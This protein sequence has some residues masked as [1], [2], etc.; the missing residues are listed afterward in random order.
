MQTPASDSDYFIV[1]RTADVERLCRD[2][3]GDR[4]EPVVGLGPRANTA[5]PVLQPGD[6]RAVVGAG[7]GIYLLAD[8]HVLAALRKLLG[9]RLCLDAGSIRVW[10]PGAR[11]GCDPAWHPHVVGL[12]DEDH[13]DTLEH[14]AHEYHLSRPLVRAHVSVIEDARA[15]LEHEMV[16]LE[17]YNCRIHERLRDVHI[18]CHALRIRAETAEA[19]SAML[20]RGAALGGSPAQPE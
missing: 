14:F 18:E 9:S 17:D 13:L 8:E 10:W 12:G 11:L 5:G 19:R 1:R 20:A 7:V 3:F 2:I 6:V 15:L 16:R 4:A